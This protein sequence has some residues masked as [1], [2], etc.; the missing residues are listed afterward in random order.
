MMHRCGGQPAGAA[1]QSESLRQFISHAAVSAD[2]RHARI[3]HAIRPPAAPEKKLQNKANFF[4]L[5]TH[6]GINEQ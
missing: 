4:S 1:P 5:H 3:L 6:A 2:G